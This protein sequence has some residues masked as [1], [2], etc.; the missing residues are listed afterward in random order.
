MCKRSSQYAP[1]PPIIRHMVRNEVPARQP[2]VA[3]P[4]RVV[5]KVAPPGTLRVHCAQDG[6]EWRERRDMTAAGDD[7]N[8]DARSEG[9]EHIFCWCVSVIYLSETLTVTV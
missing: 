1:F 4:H 9:P 7:S 8:R 6:H 3:S 5:P 2:I